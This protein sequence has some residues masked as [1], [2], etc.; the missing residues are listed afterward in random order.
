MMRPVVDQMAALAETSQVLQAIIARIMIEMGSGEDNAGPAH[1]SHFRDIG[2]TGRS[3]AM[4]APSLTGLVVPAT[5]RQTADDRA[6]CTPAALA[7][8]AGAFESH[9]PAQLRP[10]DRIIPAHLSFDR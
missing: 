8:A 2:P 5:V 4:S 7:D 1:A 9:M 6:M 3:A 10:V